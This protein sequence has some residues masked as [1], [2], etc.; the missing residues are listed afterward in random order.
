MEAGS[1]IHICKGIDQ[2]A[3]HQVRSQRGDRI[4]PWEELCRASNP[5][6]TM[7]VNMRVSY[8]LTHS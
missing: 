4:G 6:T 3:H 7:G 5:I 1:A 2:R 8:A